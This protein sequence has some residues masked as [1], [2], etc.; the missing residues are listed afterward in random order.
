[1]RRIVS[2]TLVVV[3]LVEG[4]AAEK[5]AWPRF[6]GPEGS[7]V[8]ADQ[9]IPSQLDEASRVWSAPLPGPGSSSPVVWGERVFVTSENR[10]RGLVH[11]H[12]LHARDGR[13]LWSRTVSV[14]PYRTHKMN[15]TAAATPAVAQNLVVFSW[16][17]SARKV[18]V[19]SALTH[20]GEK[21]W[22]YEI[23]QFKGA[24]GL[25]VVPVI[26]NGHVILAHLHQ[27][28]GFVVSLDA[29]SGRVVWKK[30]YAQHS[31]KTTYMTPLVR[32][33]HGRGVPQYEVV[34]SSTSIGVRGLDVKDGKELWS[35]PGVFDE[36]CIVSPVDILAGS[37]KEESLIAVGCK[38][39]GG[40]N[41]FMAVRPGD[42]KG[43]GAGVVW[44]LESFAP[45]VPT[46][47][48]D[49]T[50]LFVMADRG[51]LQAVDVMTGKPRWQKKFPANS[52]AS[53]LLIGGKLLCL[54]RDGEAYALAIGEEAMVLAISDLRPGEEVTWVDAT[55]AVAN[56][57]LYVRVGARLDCFRDG[58]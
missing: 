47:V 46:P 24:H 41:V 11:L 51:V 54:S 14:G 33:R 57:S 32:R 56:N 26:H 3:F 22:S 31:P 21:R 15:N 2:L 7:G 8:A 49:G 58:K 42:I 28:G 52:Y 19:L 5:G 53:P 43:E 35:L 48:S 20:G 27:L 18:A 45:Y 23:G 30:N 44:Q 17:D 13:S 25:N 16:Y 4:A 12:C 55:P 1:M 37:G 50:T 39:E 36:R 9:V 29:D 38:R 6:R 34:V 40:N 10:S